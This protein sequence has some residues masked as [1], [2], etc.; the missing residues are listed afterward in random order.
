MSASSTKNKGWL[1]PAEAA[2]LCKVSPITTRLWANQGKLNSSTTAGGHRR[3]SYE[4]IETFIN[5]PKEPENRPLRILIVDDEKDLTE[6]LADLLLGWSNQLEIHSVN[7][8]FEAG[9]RTVEIVPDL[10]LLDVRMRGL[11]GDD[12][13]NLIKHNPIT[14]NV[15]VIA[16]TGYPSE[17]ISQRMIKADA[18]TVLSKPFDTA[19]LYSWLDKLFG[20]QHQTHTL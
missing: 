3:F 18:I 4:D 1:S 6:L 7:N 2:K 19:E 9:M 16:M 8:G 10:V 13:C 15:P 11:Q 14:T 17:Q 5:P 12:V 20:Q